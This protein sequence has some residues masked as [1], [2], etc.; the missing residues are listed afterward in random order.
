MEV[1]YGNLKIVSQK[2]PYQEINLPQTIN[3][4]TVTISPNSTQ[5]S[6]LIMY[7]PDSVK[8][9]FIH[10]LVVNIP[11][12]SNNISDGTFIKKYYKPSPPPKTGK[13]RYIFELYYHANPLKILPN[14]NIDYGSASE[15]LSKNPNATFVK[16]L[17][18][19]SENKNQSG[20]R[21][22]KNRRRSVRR[23][24]YNKKTKRVY[25]NRK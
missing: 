18:F 23:K 3:Q 6:S 16:R 22:Y 12:N 15:I 9:I 17:V 7:D 21:K 11:K 25:K 14:E 2:L 4:P 24:I 13:H 20:G 1:S 5:L 19:L 8:G 10:W